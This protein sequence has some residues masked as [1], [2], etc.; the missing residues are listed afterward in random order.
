MY[1]QEQE[2]MEMVF[3]NDVMILSGET[4]SGKTT[5]VPQFLYEAGFARDGSIVVTQP[6]RVAAIS[7]ANRIGEELNAGESTVAYQVRYDSMVRSETKIKVL[8]EGILLKEI[9]TDFLLSNYSVVI[10]DEA[11]ERGLNTDILLGLLSRIV[12]LRAELCAERDKILEQ[13][14][15]APL[16]SPYD[17]LPPKDS[18]S[19]GH[20]KLIIMSATLR[21]T[22]FTMNPRLFPIPPPVLNVASRQYPVTLH[23]SRVTPH[24]YFNKALQK[25]ARLHRKLPPG[26]VLVF[27]TGRQE[28]EQ[29]CKKLRKLFPEPPCDKSGIPLPDPSQTK[30]QEEKGGS[31]TLPEDKKSSLLKWRRKATIM[32]TDEAAEA[33]EEQERLERERVARAGEETEE[34]SAEDAMTDKPTGDA[35]ENKELT[36][37]ELE[38]L[39]KKRQ[40]E[41]EALYELS[42]DDDYIEESGVS[43]VSDEE[44]GEEADGEK[45]SK[46]RKD[47]DEDATAMEREGKMTNSVS[48]SKWEREAAQLEMDRNAAKPL[49]VLPLYAMLPTEQQMRIF[50]PKLHN[51]GVRIVVVSTNVAETSVTIPGIRYVIDCGR[52]KSKVYDEHTGSSTF[53]IN[54]ISQASANQRAGRAGRVGAG[55]CYRLYSSAVYN[56][57]FPVHTDPEILR[58]PI[59][60][61]ILQMKSMGIR[62]VAGFPYP[63]PPPTRTLQLACHTLYILGAL[64]PIPMHKRRLLP[65]NS[66]SS[67]SENDAMKD[68]SQFLVHGRE[69]HDTTSLEI[70]DLGRGMSLFPVQPRFAKMLLAAAN[71]PGCLPLA[72]AIVAAM[73]VTE[74]FVKPEVLRMMEHEFEDSA[75]TEMQEEEQENA[76]SEAEKE[77]D[78]DNPRNTAAWKAELKALRAKK[79]QELRE[80]KRAE[81]AA[82]REKWQE[83]RARWTVPHSDHLTFLRVI[84]GYLHLRA[85]LTEKLWT[86]LDK[87]AATNLDAVKALYGNTKGLA[88]GLAWAKQPLHE[89]PWFARTTRPLEWL[90]H[91]A[92]KLVA[93]KLIEFCKDNFV[94]LKAIQEAVKLIEQLLRI[95]LAKVESSQ[96][97]SVLSTDV[98]EDLAA[99]SEVAA[100]EAEKTNIPAA[101]DEDYEDSSTYGSGSVHSKPQATAPSPAAK[102]KKKGLIVDIPTN[103]T[104]QQGVQTP[105]KSEYELRLE[106]QRA[107]L[108][109]DA[110]KIELPVPTPEQ[111]VALTQIVLSGLCDKVARRMDDV[112]KANLIKNYK[113]GMFEMVPYNVLKAEREKRKLEAAGKQYSETAETEPMLTMRDLEGAYEVINT[114][115]PVFLHP[116]SVVAKQVPE[117]VVFTEMTR[118]CGRRKRTLIS[119]LTVI[120]PEWLPKLA[121]PLCSFSAPLEDPMPIYDE[122]LDQLVAFVKAA[123]GP[124]C[125]EIPNTTTPIPNVTSSQPSI[126]SSDSTA[127]IQAQPSEEPDQSVPSRGRKP[128]MYYRHLARLF[129]EGVLVPRLKAFRP[130]LT[131]RPSS[132]VSTTTT[133][134]QIMQLVT[135][136]DINSIV[137]RKELL[138]IWHEEYN[139]KQSPEPGIRPRRFNPDFLKTEYLTW[140]NPAKRKEAASAW[141]PL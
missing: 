125:W 84:G 74:L 29:F 135:Q 45:K 87:M 51:S 39:E 63:T 32:Y 80:K 41:E 67:D 131:G 48:G 71:Q 104:A 122:H 110:S 98:F 70:T 123:Y 36:P 96:G 121:A 42:D 22:D 20:L 47:G 14:P 11:H 55:H 93:D 65:Q 24:D 52:E 50:N 16:A 35:A 79:E 100:E 27:L 33:E 82:L 60:A 17:R 9:Q 53:A 34:T 4:G 68:D 99:E 112:T 3:E 73:T 43:D 8:T 111:E 115:E 118:Q 88:M 139:R 136:F 72:T 95:V 103:R 119:S 138:E 78:D 56:E 124:H 15:K 116:D 26:G 102:P 38:A 40:E 19:K 120:K 57:H 113:P 69:F 54:F 114:K 61:T 18:V 1:A 6:R 105:Q 12:K 83:A 91:K 141:P 126:T 89:R 64:K 109:E 23:F 58:Q 30:S 132:V 86:K 81:Y 108:R 117:F 66:V 44:D 75:V 46:D 97:G 107:Y 128:P 134:H 21:V 31:S 94:R 77:K 137:G 130:Y 62:D 10:V 25:V 92:Q 133:T 37:E 106:R 129:L 49:I 85:S 7:S 76:E 140:V 101:D 127:L 59:D 90:P 13:N 28:I 2:I 5:Q